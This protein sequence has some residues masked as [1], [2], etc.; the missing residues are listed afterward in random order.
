MKLVTTVKFET[1]E[2]NDLTIA[3]DF[4]IKMGSQGEFTEEQIEKF[5]NLRKSLLTISKRDNS[6]LEV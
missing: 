3:L 2:I 5:Y 4:A 1:N 6:Y